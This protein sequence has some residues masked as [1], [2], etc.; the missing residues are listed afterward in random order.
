MKTTCSKAAMYGESSCQ[1]IGLSSHGGHVWS[2]VRC[3]IDGTDT[4]RASW[5]SMILTRTSWHEPDHELESVNEDAT[6]QK[7]EDRVF[8]VGK[9]AQILATSQ[10]NDVRLARGCD[11]VVALEDSNAVRSPRRVVATRQKAVEVAILVVFVAELALLAVSG[12]QAKG[13]KATSSGGSLP[14]SGACLRCGQDRSLGQGLSVPEC[15][16][17]P[18]RWPASLSLQAV[19]YDALTDDIRSVQLEECC[20]EIETALGHLQRSCL[21]ASSGVLDKCAA[22]FA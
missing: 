16:T 5:N 3:F 13:L 11:P 15:Q 19:L 10:L 1:Q 6:Y 4:L 9:Y 12:R 8:G 7:S 18:R 2:R 17:S 14:P 20:V 21:P 22:L